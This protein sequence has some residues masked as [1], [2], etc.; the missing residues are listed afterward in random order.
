MTIKI[1]WH[2][3]Q[4]ACG[5]ITLKLGM[6]QME[7]TKEQFADLHK[8]VGEA[9]AEFQIAPTERPLSLINTTRH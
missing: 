7:F 1:D 3:R 6:V 5:H 4:C 8:L 9:M 2:A